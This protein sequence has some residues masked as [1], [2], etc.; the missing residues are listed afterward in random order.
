MPSREEECVSSFEVDVGGL[1]ESVDV[2]G[3]SLLI[4]E[5]AAATGGLDLSV[6]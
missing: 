2:S 3:G 6:T 1:G 4:S 5:A